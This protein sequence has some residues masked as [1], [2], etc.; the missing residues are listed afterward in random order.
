MQSGKA[1]DHA[2]IKIDIAEDI[3]E[4]GRLALERIVVKQRAVDLPGLHGAQEF[5]EVRRIAGMHGDVGIAE[6]GMDLQG[7]GK[8]AGEFGAGPQA[9]SR[10]RLT[11][12]APGSLRR[13]T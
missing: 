11:S 10:R 6:S 2:H 12:S 1:E 7:N 8:V 4:S 9:P 3:G 5:R 13:S